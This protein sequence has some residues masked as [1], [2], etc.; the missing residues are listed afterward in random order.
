VVRVPNLARALRELHELGCW[1][2]GGDAHLDATPLHE[3]ADALW[4]G[5]LALVLGSEER[6]LRPAVAR[7]L[8]L[9]LRIPMRGR[10]A[11]LNVAAAAAV[12]LFEAVRRRSKG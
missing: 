5:S 11:S 10:V 4:T 9:R 8:D 1:R 7:E 3:S 6:G 12:L 2:L